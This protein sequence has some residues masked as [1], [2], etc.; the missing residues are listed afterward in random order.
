M[1]VVFDRDR[2]G[3]NN[4]YMIK[5]IQQNFIKNFGLTLSGLHLLSHTAALSLNQPKGHLLLSHS[6]TKY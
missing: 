2:F 6:L 3:A 5:L 1:A 4:I